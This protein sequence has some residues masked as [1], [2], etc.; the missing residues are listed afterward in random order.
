MLIPC[1]CGILCAIIPWNGKRLLLLTLVL[2]MTLV[3]ALARSAAAFHGKKA[4]RLTH[5][6]IAMCPLC[7]AKLLLNTIASSIKFVIALLPWSEIGENARSAG[8]CLHR[9]WRSSHT[10]LRQEFDR[11]L[12]LY[13]AGKRF[14][15]QTYKFCIAMFTRNSIALIK[16]SERHR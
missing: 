13:H 9:G 16:A 11:A 8:A 7:R 4:Y 15:T 2:S 5:V 1:R 3:E 10:C 12:G 14:L 6:V